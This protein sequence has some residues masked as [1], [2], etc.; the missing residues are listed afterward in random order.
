MMTGIGLPEGTWI[1]SNVYH[2]LL[3]CVFIL[4]PFAAR[5]TCDQFQRPRLP[6]LCLTETA[7]RA[8]RNCRVLRLGRIADKHRGNGCP[9]AQQFLDD[10]ERGRAIRS[11][12]AI[13]LND[14]VIA[15]LERLP[16]LFAAINAID[17]RFQF[18]MPQRRHARPVKAEAEK[19]TSLI[20]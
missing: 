13:N 18:V 16:C 9:T 14:I 15:P 4:L 11:Q 1:E 17:R 8:Q 12:H 19:G 5:N 2:K 7:N 6:K 20:Y 3:T 10:I